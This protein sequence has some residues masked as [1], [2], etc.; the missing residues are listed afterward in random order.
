MEQQSQQALSPGDL[1][2]Q[3]KLTAPPPRSAVVARPR[4]LDMLDAGLRGPLTLIAAPAGFGKTTLLSEWSA[5]LSDNAMPSAWLTL[6]EDDNDPLRFWRYLVAALDLLQP[7]ITAPFSAY[8]QGFQPPSLGTML[9]ALLNSLGALSTDALLVL[10]DYHAIDSP[11]IHEALAFL[12]DHLPPRLHLVIA[13]RTDPP[14]P[15]ARLRARNQLAEIRSDDLRFDP[16]EAATFLNDVMGLGL[17]ATDVSA[18]EARTEGW[19]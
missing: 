17:A 12:L 16:D 14:L 4:L 15:L 2:I 6:E 5:R 13:S 3:T 1:V 18:L 8:V 10:D 19:I 9:P 11:A 7:G